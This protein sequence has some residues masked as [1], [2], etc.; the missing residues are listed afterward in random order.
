MDKA[1][2]VKQTWAKTFE[3]AENLI[4]AV[5]LLSRIENAGLYDKFDDYVTN[6]YNCTVMSLPPDTCQ[7]IANEFLCLHGLE[8]RKG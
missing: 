2:Q 4:L 5:G 8:M 1:E 6:K 3:D 7:S